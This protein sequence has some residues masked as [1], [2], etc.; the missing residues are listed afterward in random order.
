MDFSLLF[1]RKG[2]VEI[3]IHE[4]KPK[5]R[6]VEGANRVATQS[7]ESAQVARATRDLNYP[8]RRRNSK[9]LF[10]SLGGIA[11]SARGG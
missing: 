8:E 5:L 6:L 7:L 10:G 4:T 11:V 3:Y 2:P 9:A 1:G